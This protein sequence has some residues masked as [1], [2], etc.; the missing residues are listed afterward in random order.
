MKRATHA[1]RGAALLA[2][3]ITVTL[4][5][6]LAAAALWRQWRGVEVEAA[7]RARVQSAWLLTGALDWS[8][9][10]LSGDYSED[11]RKRQMVDH[12]GEPWAVPLAEAR[13]STFLAAG[14]SSSD[15][16]RDAFL[17]G[18]VTDLQ[19]R[20]NV[21]NLA[22]GDANGRQEAYL[23]F[24]RL[25]E[26]LNL[27]NAE[28][29]L[30]RDNLQRAADAMK[31]AAPDGNDAPLLPRRFDQLAWLGLSPE[32]LQVLRPY[33]TVLPLE[34][35]AATKVNVNTAPAPVL[36]A[37]LGLNPADAQRLVG[38]RE[39]DFFKDL[40]DARLQRAD[41]A[42]AGVN[43]SFFEVRGRLR[44]DDVAL[45]EVS[46]VRRTG[47]NRVSTLWRERAAL[48]VPVAR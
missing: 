17:S 2:A 13:L 19:S 21:M 4:V 28:L 31:A 25:F 18:E 45:E 23:R 32:S 15:T 8:R 34:G 22:V 20:L 5:A 14:E 36:V 11:E 6:T 7:E 9:L 35:S 46:V 16:H 3:M 44:L 48:S 33:L 38:E 12:L 10:I 1:Q 43:S 26:L 29:A 42:W 41:T 40:A 30:L 39:R 37:A 24:Q 47:R 27:R